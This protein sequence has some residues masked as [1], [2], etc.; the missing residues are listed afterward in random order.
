MKLLWIL[1]ILGQ[2]L[3]AGNMNYQQANGY[4]EINDQ[5]YGKHPSKKEVYTIKALE[6]G[7][8]YGLTKILPM[9]KIEILIGANL[10]VFGVM[11]YDNKKSVKFGFEW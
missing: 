5:M 8:V 1:F 3:N 6:V 9:C 10:T 7:G 4:Y 11:I 2:F